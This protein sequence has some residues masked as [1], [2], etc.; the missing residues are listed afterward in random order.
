[1]LS[2][3]WEF[4]ALRKKVTIFKNSLATPFRNEILMLWKLE[5]R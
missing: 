2:S 5:A 4:A 3:T 1:M